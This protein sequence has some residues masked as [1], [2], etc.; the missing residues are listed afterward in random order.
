LVARSVVLESLDRVLKTFDPEDF[1]FDERH[2]VAMLA[3]YI[4]D[5]LDDVGWLQV[6]DAAEVNDPDE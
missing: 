5:H 1:S 3:E 6:T 2:D 4:T